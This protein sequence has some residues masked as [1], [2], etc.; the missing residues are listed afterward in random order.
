MNINKLKQELIKQKETNFKE[1]T[2]ELIVDE[3]SAWLS[4]NFW[5]NKK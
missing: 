5:N 1:K 3:E 4:Q 2:I